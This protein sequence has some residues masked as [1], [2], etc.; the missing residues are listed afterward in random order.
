MVINERNIAFKVTFSINLI[1]IVNAQ[2]KVTKNILQAQDTST[3]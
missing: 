2:K 3:S 1:Y